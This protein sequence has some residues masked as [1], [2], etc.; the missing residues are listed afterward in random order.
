MIRVIIERHCRPDKVAEMESQLID[1]R[2]TAMRQSGYISGETLHSVDDPTLWLV[3]STWVDI[4]AWKL[5]GTSSERRQNM[6]SLE[7]LLA[8]P[9][10]VS[11][12][13]F[14]RRGGATSAYTLG[15]LEGVR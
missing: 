12:F 13:N 4:N 11:V 1:L 9:E 10:K 5:W 7:P 15:K 14:A 3:I 8:V 6:Q 2:T